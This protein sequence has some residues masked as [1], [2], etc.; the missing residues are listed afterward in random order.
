MRVS[1]V[2]EDLA[3]EYAEEK[4][5]AG[6]KR[7]LTSVLLRVF[8]SAAFALSIPGF[9]HGARWYSIICLLFGIVCF[10]IAAFQKIEGKARDVA[11][12][13]LYIILGIGTLIGGVIIVRVYAIGPE[14]PGAVFSFALMVWFFYLA[15]S[16]SKLLRSA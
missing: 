8:G 4:T 9:V 5:E 2:P 3:K 15:H 6:R 16:T 1:E 13:A 12:L 11:A 14:T 7:F 10:I